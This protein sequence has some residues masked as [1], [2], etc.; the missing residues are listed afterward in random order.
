MLNKAG[1]FDSLFETFHG[2]LEA[3]G[4][5]ARKGQMIDATF[6]E[7]PRQRNPKE[8]NAQIK[9]GKVPED[10]KAKPAKA[11]QKDV[12]ARWTRK[13]ERRYFTATRI[14]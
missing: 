1:L 12:D 8:E 5:I 11:R 6:V 4:M 3:R 2:T 10:W 7:A 9:E 13:H 14:T